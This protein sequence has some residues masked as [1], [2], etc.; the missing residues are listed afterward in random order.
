MVS[1]EFF[2]CLSNKD[3]RINSVSEMLDVCYSKSF[4]NLAIHQDKIFVTFLL[5]NKLVLLF[6]R[7]N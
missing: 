1:K 7:I 5:D 4:E 6:V 2:V 3:P